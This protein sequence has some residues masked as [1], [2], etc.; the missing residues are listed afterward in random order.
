MICGSRGNRR[1]L[2]GWLRWH[3]HVEIAPR[4]TCPPVPTESAPLGGGEVW[5]QIALASSK[6][7]WSASLV[8]LTVSGPDSSAPWDLGPWGASSRSPAGRRWADRQAS[9]EMAVLQGRNAMRQRDIRVCASSHYS[10]PPCGCRR[11][12][13]AARRNCSWMADWPDHDPLGGWWQANTLP[14]TDRRLPSATQY[15]AISESTGH[16]NHCALASP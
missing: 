10:F 2:D 12:T 1:R 3:E 5:E 13:G 7:L 8:H 16:A 6:P 11:S 15:F 14:S 4:V 9:H